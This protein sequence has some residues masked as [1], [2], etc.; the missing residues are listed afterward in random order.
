MLG[1]GLNDAGA[2]Q[3][4]DTGVAVSQGLNFTP[5]SDIVLDADQLINLHKLFSFAKEAN[6]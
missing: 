1:D 5:A 6:K 4:S 2:L 3:Q